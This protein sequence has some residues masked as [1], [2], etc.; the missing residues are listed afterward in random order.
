MEC[1]DA[2]DPSLSLDSIFA[3]GARGACD[4]ALM[5]DWIRG[6]ELLAVAVKVAW[7]S[8]YTP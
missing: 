6:L 2:T 1:V 8:P 5:L 3:M 7:R 4:S